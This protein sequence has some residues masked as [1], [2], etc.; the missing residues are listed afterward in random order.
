[1]IPRGTPTLRHESLLVCRAGTSPATCDHHRSRA[2]RQDT[3]TNQPPY[4]HAGVST[5]ARRA[6]RCPGIGNTGD[7]DEVGTTLAVAVVSAPVIAVVHGDAG[8]A[9]IP[10]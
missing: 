7:G 10:G 6:D 5:S 9:N 3:A 4:D 2:C 8:R 1:M